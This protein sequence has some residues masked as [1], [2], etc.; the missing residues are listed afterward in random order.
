MQ[1]HG[2]LLLAMEYSGSHREPFLLKGSLT[3]PMLDCSPHADSTA[4]YW[5]PSILI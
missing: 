3:Q 1:W 5:L 4:S 2:T